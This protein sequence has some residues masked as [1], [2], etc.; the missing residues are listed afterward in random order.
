MTQSTDASSMVLITSKQSP[1]TII[2]L[3]YEKKGVMSSKKRESNKENV[4][5]VYIYI[6]IYIY[7]YT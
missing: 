4:P 6:Y 7:T 2:R 5:C 1:S 3:I